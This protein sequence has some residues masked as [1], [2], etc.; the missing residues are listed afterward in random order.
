MAPDRYD[1]L[2]SLFRVLVGGIFA[3][4]GEDK[5]SHPSAFAARLPRLLPPA[6][7]YPG[8][9]H[10]VATLVLPH[11]LVV[12]WIAGLAEM[13]IGLGLVFGLGHRLAAWAGAAYMVLLALARGYPGHALLWRYFFAGLEYLALAML[14]V[15]IAADPR[16]R[17]TI[18]GLIRG[19]K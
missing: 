3:L 7:R 13:A 11:A 1:A 18:D 6:G 14:F 9:G 5:L 4:I 8:F 2:R 16:P 15:L 19:R 17:F 10:V 12:A